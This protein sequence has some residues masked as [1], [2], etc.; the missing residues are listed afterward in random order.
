VNEVSSIAVF[1]GVAFKSVGAGRRGVGSNED[2]GGNHGES[3]EIK[4]NSARMAHWKEGILTIG[5]INWWGS[6][7]K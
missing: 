6:G 7:Y 3:S 1:H 2:H 4:E 5:I